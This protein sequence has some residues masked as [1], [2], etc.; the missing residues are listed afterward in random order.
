MKAMTLPVRPPILPRAPVTPLAAPAMAGPAA[1][2]TRDR[3][4]EALL[5]VSLAAAVAFSVDV[6][7]NRREARRRAGE[8]SIGR[9]AAEDMLSD[10]G[11]G[12]E[13]LG[14]EGGGFAADVDGS[15]GE[16]RRRGRWPGRLEVLLRAGFV[17]REKKSSGEFAGRGWLVVHWLAGVF[18]H[19]AGQQPP[20]VGWR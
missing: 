1:L 5:A 9:A 3:P 4:W 13:K 15:I 12:E 8:R 19:T 6:L 17:V 11:N 7:W 14:N 2:V 20:D 10:L 18:G 16:H